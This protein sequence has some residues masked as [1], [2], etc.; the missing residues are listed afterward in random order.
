MQKL[1][2]AGI[3]LMITGAVARADVV[4]YGFHCISNNQPSSCAIGEAQLFVDVVGYGQ[5]VTIGAGNYGPSSAGE[6]LFRFRNTGPSASVITGVYF[7]DGSLLSLASLIGMTGVQ[8][9]TGGSPHNLPAGNSINP[10]FNATFRA[11]ADQPGPQ[12]GVGP[13]EAL[14]VLFAL[15]SGMTWDDVVSALASRD[16]RIGLHVQ[17]FQEGD[18]ESFV[19]NGV[20]PEPAAI[21]LVGSVLLLLGRRLRARKA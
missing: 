3:L 1:H 7:D 6:V 11:T 21:L 15:Q 18:S 20:V 10:P 19:N 9:S 8:F 13:S 17:A 5:T 16:L 12:N 14:G 2:A 4:T